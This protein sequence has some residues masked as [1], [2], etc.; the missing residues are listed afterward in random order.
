MHVRDATAAASRRLLSEHLGLEGTTVGELLA[1][2]DAVLGAR[3]TARCVERA[4]DVPLSWRGTALGAVSALVAGT[5]ALGG[6]WWSSSRDG[7][8]PDELL[9]A[10]SGVRAW[11]PILVSL[12]YRIEEDVAVAEW[13]PIAGDVDL[14]S[15]IA[16]DR[17]AA[18]PTARAGDRLVVRFDPGSVVDAI[19]EARPGSQL[20]TRLDLDTIRHTVPSEV[21]WAWGVMQPLVGP[22]P[23]PGDDPD[24][25]AREV[26]PAIV[27]ALQAR[28]AELA[29][30]AAGER[31]RTCGD[32]CRAFACVNWN[33]VPGTWF[34]LMR[35]GK[36]LVDDDKVELADRLA[37]VGARSG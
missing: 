12:E 13:G 3:R 30:E 35:A 25:Y 20:G 33:A 29:P 19:V 36:A 2:A 15:L 1:C 7:S 34:S 31:W 14:N 17:I 6:S 22:W 9:A 11:P 10:P 23:L 37:R 5:R 8:T 26:D 4:R 32:V 27:E 24:P 16:I 21:A 18:P 28:F